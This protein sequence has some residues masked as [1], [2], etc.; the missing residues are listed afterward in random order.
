MEGP[1][2]SPLEL[3]AGG[4]GGRVAA[5]LGDEQP[6]ISSV[7]AIPVK[8]ETTDPVFRLITRC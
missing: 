1:L 8:I 6:A 2:A 5:G 7:S 4:G 3:A